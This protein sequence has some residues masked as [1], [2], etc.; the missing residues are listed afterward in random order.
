MTASLTESTLLEKE[1]SRSLKNNIKDFLNHNPLAIAGIVI[2]VL[3]ILI[4]L[5]GTILAPYD[6]IKP[7]L[8]QKLQEPSI[9]HILGTDDMGRDILSRIMAGTKISLSSA[10]IIISISMFIGILIGVIAGY[11][12]GW[13]DD[14]LMRLTDIFLAF[15]ALILAMSISATLGPSLNN[16]LIAV[17]LVWWPWYARLARAQVIALQQKEFVT[18]ARS[19]GASDARI[20]F[21]H[22]LAN[23]WGPLIVQATLDIGNTILL[24]ASLS[25][26]G[27]GAQPPTPEWGAMVSIGRIYMLSY[28][29]VPT[30]PGLAILISVLGFNLLGDALRDF[31]DVR[32]RSY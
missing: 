11:A 19:I 12:G 20:I 22:I 21:K 18:A 28:W 3:T 10:A 6:P 24:T 9:L 14:I 1:N 13:L 30:M 25:F 23:A 16:A 32:G 7:E 26:I 4:A 8:T 15:P 27:L 29:W 5:F 2:S 17:S 31:S